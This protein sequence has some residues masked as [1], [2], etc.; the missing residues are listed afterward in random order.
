MLEI[1]SKESLHVGLLRAGWSLPRGL[2]GEASLI[3]SAK[4]YVCQVFW[5]RNPDII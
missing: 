4:N 3:F 1:E 2:L 5:V